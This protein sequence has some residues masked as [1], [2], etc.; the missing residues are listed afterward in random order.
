MKNNRHYFKKALGFLCIALLLGGA[1]SVKA[2]TNEKNVDFNLNSLITKNEDVREVNNL[3]QINNKTIKIKEELIKN[4]KLKSQSMVDVPLISLEESLT[5]EDNTDFYFFNVDS[6]KTM[7][8][9]MVSSNSNYV[10]QLG[11]VNWQ[12]GTFN[13]TDIYVFS[14]NQIKLANLPTGSYGIRVF[15]NNNT[16]G[17]KYTLRMNA[18]NPGGDNSTIL[19]KSDS[20]KYLTIQYVNKDIYSNGKYVCNLDKDNS[21]LN[22]EREFYFPNSGGYTSRKHSISD[23]KIKSV[24]GPVSYKSSYASSANAMLIYLDKGTLFTYFESAFQSGV[25]TSYHNSFVDTT[26]KTTPRRIDAEDMTT[27]GDHI[28]VV[29]LDTGKSIDFFSVLNFYYASGI[30]PIPTINFLN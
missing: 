24:S 10:A 6:T 16:V 20:L 11:I 9:N 12:D 3:G 2:T 22:W 1:I 19:R 15:S 7:L 27:Y 5:A 13:P 8:M 14:G 4:K 30:E 29:D 17:D 23:M 28:L 25:N 26:G 21:Q 18:L